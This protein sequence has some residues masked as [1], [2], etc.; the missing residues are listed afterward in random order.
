M[1]WK[2]TAALPFTPPLAMAELASRGVRH[3]MKSIGEI[4][5]AA[6]EGRISGILV[7][8]RAE[9]GQPQEPQHSDPK[10]EAGPTGPVR[11]VPHE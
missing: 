3:T 7:T 6:T 1:R 8:P 9:V 11:G 10:G 5:I 4:S 2:G